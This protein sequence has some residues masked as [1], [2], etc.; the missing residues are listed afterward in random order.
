MNSPDTNFAIP[1]RLLWSTS[2]IL[3]LSICWSQNTLAESQQD[4]LFFTSIDAF[5]KIKGDDANVE[6]SFIRP[7]ID[8]LY[9]YSGDKFR[10]LGEYLWSSDESELER[11]KLGW[12]MSD[13][14][15]LWFGRFH[16]TSKYWTSEYHHGQF[17]QTS[18]TRPRV[19]EWEDESGPMPSHITGLSLGHQTLR[20]NDSAIDYN[21][22]V[23]LAPQFSGNELVPFDVLNPD[24]GHG[25]AIN[26]GMMFR[27]AVVDA[28]QFGLLMGWYDINVVS[29]SNPAL[30]DLNSM[31][32]FTVGLV[33]DWT[34]GP[35]RLI[36]NFVYF[37]NKLEYVSRS[38]P[39]DFILGYLQ[40]EYAVSDNWRI[41]GRIDIGF[42]E[43]DS[44][45][46]SMLPAFIAH[47]NM[48][49]WRWDFAELQSFSMEVADSSAQQ[50]LLGHGNFKEIRVQWSAVF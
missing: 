24:S 41:F 20:A 28:N 45:Y 12:Q 13:Q 2:I 9:S 33:A 7:S 15:M 5:K 11:I 10:F 43:D 8:V 30:A 35:L 49:G 23:G 36:G 4:L 22:S 48:L 18:I 31:R 40:A 16:A 50:G 29:E 38:V 32:Q 1:A 14:T 3:C 34:R 46:L 21:I 6:D 27:P 25:L 47:R 26:Y 42:D 19:D 37:D 17:L 44:L 39:E